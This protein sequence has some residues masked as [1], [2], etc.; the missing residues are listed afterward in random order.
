MNDTIESSTQDPQGSP[1][2]LLVHQ[3]PPEPAYLRVKVRRRLQRLGAVALKNS[4][5]V[6]PRRD[7]TIEDFQWLAGEIRAEGGEATVCEAALLSGVTDQQLEALFREACDATYAEIERLARESGAD[8]DRLR[9]RLEE[10]GSMDFFDADGRARAERAVANLE[11]GAEAA[12]E[13]RPG[14]DRGTTW[15]TRAGVKVDRMSS[16]WLIRR[17]IDPDARFRFAPGKSAPRVAGEQRFDMFEGEYTHEGDR[18]TFEVLLERFHLDDP[19]LRAIGQIVHD[20]DLKDDKFRRPETRGIAAVID[21][22]V[23][24]TPRDEDRLAQGATMLDG[25]YARLRE[26]PGAGLSP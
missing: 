9:Q 1:W 7:D 4:V 15:V 19:A 16:A 10:V 5:Y 8:A 6:L 24:G 18:C 22:I 11:H 12:G 26:S 14:P 3:L 21:G 23:L 17:F 25:L 13:G 20:I 2:L